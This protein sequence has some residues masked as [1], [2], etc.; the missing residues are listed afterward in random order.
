MQTDKQ[1]DSH[2][3]DRAGR[4]GPMACCQGDIGQPSSVSFADANETSQ[5]QAT[6][7]KPPLETQAEPP[8]LLRLQLLH[9]PE[10]RGERGGLQTV[11]LSRVS[12]T[13]LLCDPRLPAFRRGRI[14]LSF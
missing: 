4:E 13:C 7:A 12:V 6:L 11:C 2:S 14:A 8:P 10:L 3:A 1:T 9:T 5:L